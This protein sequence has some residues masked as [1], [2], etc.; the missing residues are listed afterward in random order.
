MYEKVFIGEDHILGNGKFLRHFMIF[1]EEDKIFGG[2]KPSGYLKIETFGKEGKLSGY[3]ENLSLFG[4]NISRL[5]LISSK[6]NEWA[7]VEA[8]KS[9]PGKDRW[10]I[11]WNFESDNVGN[12]GR[13]VADFDIAA[14]VLWD[15]NNNIICPL[16]YYQGE[17]IEWK[18]KLKQFLMGKKT[19]AGSGTL[20]EDRQASEQVRESES[21]PGSGNVTDGYYA[22]ID[23]IDISK[24]ETEVKI[25]G[26]IEYDS[27]G[28]VTDLSK[29]KSIYRP[30]EN[31]PEFNIPDSIKKEI[32]GPENKNKETGIPEGADKTVLPS[33]N[34]TIDKI[35]NEGEAVKEADMKI[36][37]VAKN[38]DVKATGGET[39]AIAEEDAS[40][41]L[42]KEDAGKA[43][44][45]DAG[46][47]NEQEETGGVRED[48]ETSAPGERETVPDIIRLINALDSAFERIDPFGSRRRDYRWW[49]VINPMYLS[50]VLY[51]NGIKTPLLFNTAVMN[52]HYKYGHLIA[53]VY[54]DLREKQ[55]AYFVCGVPGMYREEERPFGEYCRW[56]RAGFRQGPDI[57]GYWL[58]YVDPGTGRILKLL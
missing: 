22:T 1:S 25:T 33:E 28:V 35:L 24:I 4:D 36:S 48:R 51:E 21:S 31:T 52:A 32:S 5:Y 46:V 42:L 2:K 30:V 13:N 7:F 26:D 11:K 6:N 20:K 19:T 15:K 14:I 54:E 41:A 8:G 53:G 27:S 23:N 43:E 47:N 39:T 29:I 50:N 9:E 57:V 10:D 12:T 34:G 45:E 49:K 44:K 38:I 37:D 16:A 3:A 18:P 40:G 58:I 17:K 56:V 55:K